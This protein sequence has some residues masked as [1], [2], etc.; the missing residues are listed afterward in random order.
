[1]CKVYSNPALVVPTPYNLHIQEFSCHF[2]ALGATIS[3]K[4][5]PLQPPGRSSDPLRPCCHGYRLVVATLDC[6]RVLTGLSNN[7]LV[8]RK[9]HR[10]LE[11]MP[12][13][14]RSSQN[15]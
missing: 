3:G 11:M 7:A 14:H 4:I 10:T 1:M 5:D 6:T 15:P 2:L 12:K 13:S 9:F 8:P